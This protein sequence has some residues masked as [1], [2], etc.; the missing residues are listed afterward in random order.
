M[1][2]RYQVNPL[3]RSFATLIGSV[4]F[5]CA[6][7]AST[8]STASPV[9]A[10][11]PDT[12]TEAD[13]PRE[14]KKLYGAMMTFRDQFTL[15]PP[16]AASD[17]QLE[18]FTR[19]AFPNARSDHKP[20]KT[21]DAAEAL[22]FWLSKISTDPRKPF[23]PIEKD[24]DPKEL[25]YKFYE[26]DAKRLK[27]GRYYPTSDFKTDPF[28]YFDAN[29]YKIAK[30]KDFEPYYLPDAKKPDVR[31][32]LDP[33]TCQIIGPGK[34]GKLGR[35]GSLLELSEE[36]RDNVAS[37]AKEPIGKVDWKKFEFEVE[38]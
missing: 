35:G 19:R 26:F 5:G 1:A 24:E 9:T 33:E 36:D 29:T 16:S 20:E 21:P 4:M 10:E 30:H 8:L 32:Y 37:F 25:R 15:L 3:R 2:W 31:H 12:V 18:R 28:I 34:D 11:E 17:K 23:S 38:E 22:P 7:I 6:L 27:D 14:V 13:Q